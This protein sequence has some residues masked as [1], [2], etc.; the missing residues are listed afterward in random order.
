[1]TVRMFAR[2]VLPAVAA[3]AVVAPATAQIGGLPII[4]N[5]TPMLSKIDPLLQASLG[6]VTGRSLVIV[7]AVD[8]ASIGAV[9]DLVARTGGTPGRE[10]PIIEAL[11]ATVPNASLGVLTNSPLVRRL[12]LDRFVL[13]SVDRTAATIGSDTV[14]RDFTYDGSGIGVAVIDSGI[15]PSHDD[16]RAPD[17]SGSQRVDEFVDFVN[18]AGTPHD[19]YGHGTHVAG[20]IAGNGFDTGG[21]R[22]GMAPGARLT[23][24]KVLDGLGRG[25]ISQVIAALGYVGELS[26][27]TPSHTER[28]VRDGVA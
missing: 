27:R 14:R 19:G 2:Y 21:A 28:T 12:A 24:L 23:V 22:A 16:L 26:A 11:A 5:A 3:L 6:D 4:N 17:G 7:R 25:R 13:G 10:L 9:R 15:T 20:I 8:L 18:G 1:M